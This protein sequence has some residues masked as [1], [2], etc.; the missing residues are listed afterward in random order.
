[1]FRA[2][3]FP[4]SYTIDLLVNGKPITKTAQIKA[5]GNS[6]CPPIAAAIVAANVEVAAIAVA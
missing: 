5:C 6:V 3:G 1:L 2:Q 4:D